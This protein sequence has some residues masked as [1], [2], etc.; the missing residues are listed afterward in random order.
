MELKLIL[1]SQLEKHAYSKVLVKFDDGDYRLGS[2]TCFERIHWDDD[3]SYSD[4]KENM[5]LYL[6]T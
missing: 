4:V 3:S 2:I 6:L 1:R 5:K